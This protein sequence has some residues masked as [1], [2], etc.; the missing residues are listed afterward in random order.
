[1]YWMTQFEVK[2]SDS[3][4]KHWNISRSSDLQ[5]HCSRTTGCLNTSQHRQEHDID[6]GQTHTRTHTHTPLNRKRQKRFTHFK[7]LLI[8]GQAVLLTLQEDGECACEL[9][10][11]VDLCRQAAAVVS[12]QH[13]GLLHQPGET[14]SRL[15]IW[16]DGR[17]D[18]EGRELRLALL[19]SRGLTLSI[20][21]YC[22]APSARSTL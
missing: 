22:A 3:A 11:V 18:K 9:P 1:M 14:L 6:G 19:T 7:F 8:L 17:A 12:Q 16:G 5:R 21:S 4:T 10:P 20:H 13:A 2:K 15:L